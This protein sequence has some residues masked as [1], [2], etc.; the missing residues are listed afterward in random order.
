MR[1]EPRTPDETVNVS[2]QQPLK[3]AALL[4]LGLAALAA[5]VALVVTHGVDLLAP[6]I[7]PQV[8]HR[9]FASLALDFAG[10]VDDD[11]EL[12]GRVAQAQSLVDRLLGHWPE[13][14]TRYRIGLLAS[15]EPNAAAFPGG[16]ILVTQGLL[17]DVR[18]E[19]ELAFVLAH[20][21]GHFRNRDH[22]RRLGRGI[23]YGLALA[24]LVRSGGPALDL[25]TLVGELTTRGF[26]GEQETAADLFGLELVHAEYGHVASAVDFFERRGDEEGRLDDRA[27]Y[28]STHPGSDDRANELREWALRR[29]WAV[30]GTPA[31]LAQIVR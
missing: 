1:F 16:W 14:P 3:E 8:E 20:E 13:A 21:L 23:V 18:T 30:E 22:L 31:E 12:A 29:G 15:T 17:A 10:Q 26:D 19:N 27:I 7:P 28:L 6:R 4:T 24:T 9:V 11:A 2:S 25:A 5:L